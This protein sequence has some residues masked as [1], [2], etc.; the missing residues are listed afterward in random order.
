[1]YI[2]K[3][4]KYE[5]LFGLSVTNFVI[6]FPFNSLFIKPMTFLLISFGNGLLAL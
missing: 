2:K 6:I 4:V 3:S 1:M 5:Y